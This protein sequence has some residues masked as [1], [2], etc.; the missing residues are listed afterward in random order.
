MNVLLPFN[1]HLSP[2]FTA[3]VRAPP[4]SE[5]EPGSVSPHAPSHSPLASFGIHR[6]LCSSLPASIM[7]FVH[8]ELCAATIIPTLPST[9]D[10]SSTASTY[11]TYPFPAPPNDSGKITPSSPTSP[12]FFTTAWGNSLF[13]SHSLT[14]GPIPP[15]ANARPAL[16][17]CLCSSV[18]PTIFCPSVHIINT[19]PSIT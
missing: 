3:V 18:N 7:W 13:S 4:A 8:S 11:S 12:S 9:R 19:Y 16:C 17:N 10:S 1:T 6:F 5:P 15:S 2:F 14:C